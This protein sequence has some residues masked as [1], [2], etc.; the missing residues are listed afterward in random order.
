MKPPVDVARTVRVSIFLIDALPSVL[1]LAP[2]EVR[3]RVSPV[4]APP[5]MLSNPSSVLLAAVAAFTAALKVSFP[6]VPVKVSV[7]VVSVR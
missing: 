1:A 6:L 5:S 3:S 7:L 2:V 4:P